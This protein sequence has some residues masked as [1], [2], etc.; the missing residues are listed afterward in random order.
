MTADRYGGGVV[1]DSTLQH[2]LA[3]IDSGNRWNLSE[4]CSHS[5]NFDIIY[6]EQF[7][8]VS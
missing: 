8:E 5:C 7:H 2:H 3:V 4:V 6:I 1:I